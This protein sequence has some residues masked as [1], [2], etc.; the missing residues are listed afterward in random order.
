MP[1]RSMAETL[2]AVGDGLLDEFAEI[3]REGHA[4]Y[5][6]YKP[7]DLIELDVRAQSAAR[8]AICTLR[9]IDGS[10]IVMVSAGLKFLVD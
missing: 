7:A 3:V 1:D 8:I 4:R 2:E 10:L 5:M 6:A 9:L